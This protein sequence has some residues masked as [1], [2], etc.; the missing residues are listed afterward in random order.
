[1]NAGMVTAAV[2]VACVAVLAAGGEGGSWEAV[3]EE[4]RRLGK[5]AWRSMLTY[6]AALHEKSTHPPEHPFDRPWEE[7]GPGY[8]FGRAFG[9]WDIVHQVMD[10]L[11]T[12]PEHALNQLLNNLQNQQPS[13]FVPGSIWMPGGMSGRKKVGWSGSG[14]GHPP[15]WV[16]AVGDHL[17][18]T[19][20]TEH[21]GRFYEA[22]V[23]QIAWFEGHRKAEGEGF[24]Y[25]DITLK[26][27]ESGVDEGV[28]FDD[29][30]DAAL[31]CIDATCHV[32]WLYE[33]AAAWARELGEDAGP[34]EQRARELRGFIR[35]DLYARDE[36]MF[37]DVWAMRD[38]ALRHLCFES[39][40]PIVTGAATEAQANRY[41]DEYLLNPRVFFTE[42]PIATVGRTDR[43]FELRM[44][45]G[46]AW[47]SMTYWA[48]RGCLNYGRADAAIK[49]G[50]RALDNAAKQFERTGT[51]W[52]FYHPEGGRPEDVRRKGRRPDEPC[53]DYLGHNPLI[54]IARMYDRL[55]HE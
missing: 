19:G 4:A 28:R 17:E 11:P 36:G 20:D 10:T 22:L 53:A 49:L 1:M 6:V 55:T 34:Y 44:W 12:Y 41:I 48:M 16:A 26:K 54:A 7:I 5:P 37:Y 39:M 3:R 8:V 13:G 46:P 50:E 35:T 23:K 31:A 45:R 43:K 29:S 42:H 21:L 52:E 30:P 47:N 27:W 40:W 18:R 15:V 32:Y 24:Y 9:H 38:E 51:I 2:V 14:Q 25:T 33:H